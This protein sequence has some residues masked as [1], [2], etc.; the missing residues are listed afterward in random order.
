M[1]FLI[2]MLFHYF[3]LKLTLTLAFVGIGLAGDGLEFFYS[4]VMNLF[5]REGRASL[6]TMEEEV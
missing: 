5:S 1:L 3:T 2:I 6:L 4:V